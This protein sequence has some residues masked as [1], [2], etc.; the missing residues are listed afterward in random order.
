M[1]N[2]IRVAKRSGRV[3]VP[4]E[5]R[6]YSGGWIANDTSVTVTWHHIQKTARIEGDEKDPAQLA[7]KLLGEII[8]SI[9]TV[10][11]AKKRAAT[12]RHAKYRS[13][14]L[15][16]RVAEVNVPQTL[17]GCSAHRHRAK[18]NRAAF[19]A[20]DVR[21][22]GVSRCRSKNCQTVAAV[23]NPP[24][25]FAFGHSCPQPLML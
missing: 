2:Q 22:H 24:S 25:E 10:D 11:K 16:L 1:T 15:V 18:A 9:V 8:R 3:G 23:S 13:P 12:G 20:L 7:K 14:L 21:H 4:Y 17:S 6:I 5:R 19:D